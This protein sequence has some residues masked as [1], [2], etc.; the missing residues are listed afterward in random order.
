MHS[1]E[2]TQQVYQELA[3]AFDRQQNPGMRDLFLMLAADT[4]LRV[5]QETE[6]E[7]LRQRLLRLNPSHMLR[8]YS[9]FA[10]AASYPDI[11]DYLDGLRQKYPPEAAEEMLESIVPV[12]PSPEDDVPM[13]LPPTPRGQLGWGGPPARPKEEEPPVYRLRPEAGSGGGTPR[14]GP[15]EEEEPP[16]YPMHPG[17]GETLAPTPRGGGGRPVGRPGPRPAADPGP[18]RRPEE[19]PGIGET[20]PPQRW[21]GPPAGRQDTGHGGGIG[22]TMPPRRVPV[23]PPAA[24]DTGSPPVNET[25]PPRRAPLPSSDYS[26]GRGTPA[27]DQTLDPRALPPRQPPGPRQP[28]V[29][30]SPV[31]PPA[32]PRQPTFEEADS[33]AEKPTSGSWVGIVL[34]I[35]M[36]G[37]SVALTVMAFLP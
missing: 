14:G 2:H 29:R 25:I 15:E 18:P 32:E 8:P 35:L 34:F 20:M 37:V 24:R 4:A 9:S 11:R 6:A 22:E 19:P 26:S 27:I 33:E 5:G 12:S 28:A 17:L 1:S 7:R 3:D 23:P 31:S 16:V 36:L 10:E 21:A 30:R 13:T